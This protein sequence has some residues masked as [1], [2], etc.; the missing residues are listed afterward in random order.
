MVP[1]T[2]VSTSQFSSILVLWHLTYWEHIGDN[3]QSGDADP[4]TSDDA[5]QRVPSETPPMIGDFDDNANA[6]WSL[7]LGEAKSHDEGRI[8]SLKDD[9]DSVL[10]FV[11]VFISVIIGYTVLMHY[12][13]GRFILCCPYIISRR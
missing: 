11:R 4:G 9:M 3:A 5:A 10:I 13:Q 6:M 7:H 1:P 8:H 2:P 12:L